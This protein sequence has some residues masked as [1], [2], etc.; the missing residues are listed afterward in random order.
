MQYLILFVS[1]IDKIPE[2]EAFPNYFTIYSGFHLC[3]KF[4]KRYFS[5]IMVDR[6][7]MN[8]MHAKKF[9]FKYWQ[10]FDPNILWKIKV[11][12]NLLYAI[13]KQFLHK[14]ISTTELTCF[15][16]DVLLD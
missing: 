10:K 8:F 14:F 5:K 7:H 4:G 11:H 12:R 3:A 6:V 15:N 1:E 2:I 13:V 16:A 9:K